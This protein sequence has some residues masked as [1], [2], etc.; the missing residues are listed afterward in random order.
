MIFITESLLV[1]TFLSMT[2]QCYK[3]YPPQISW[4]MSVIMSIWLL[5]AGLL[6]AHITV[7]P[8]GEGA[9]TLP[10]KLGQNTLICKDDSV[11][12]IKHC[13]YECRRT[14][15]FYSRQTSFKHWNEKPGCG[16]RW[17]GHSSGLYMSLPSTGVWRHIKSRCHK[18]DSR[19]AQSNRMSYVS[20]FGVPYQVT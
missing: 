15:L 18:K 9:G 17:S 11:I 8:R 3:K 1:S 14:I 7:T 4:Q 16:P 6:L 13:R 20:P 12:G 19:N 10:P 5:L 2:K